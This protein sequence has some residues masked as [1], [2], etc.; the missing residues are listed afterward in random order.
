[1]FWSLSSFILLFFTGIDAPI[2]QI[3]S[4]R[5]NFPL[6]FLLAEMQT[7]TRCA[8][9]SL[10][11]LTETPTNNPVRLSPSLAHLVEMPTL[12]VQSKESAQLKMMKNYF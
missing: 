5:V 9:L 10:A 4:H 7:Q 1:M 6:R 2:I 3:I 12:K 8:S 11:F